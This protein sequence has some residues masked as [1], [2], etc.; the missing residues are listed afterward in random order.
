[1]PFSQHLSVVWLQLSVHTLSPPLD[2]HGLRTQLFMSLSLSLPS[3][4]PGLLT[5]APPRNVSEIDGNRNKDG[6]EGQAVPG[7]ERSADVGHTG[8]AVPLNL[9]VGDPSSPRFP[10]IT[11]PGPPGTQSQVVQEKPQVRAT[12]TPTQ[13]H[14]HPVTR[15]YTH[16]HLA[17]QDSPDT[18]ETWYRARDSDSGLLTTQGAVTS[19]A[20]TAQQSTREGLRGLAR[21][22]AGPQT[23]VLEL[24][25][26]RRLSP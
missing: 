20:G 17:T 9:S 14:R 19:E 7:T 13:A 1:M 23:E 22:T 25:K 10:P 21:P 18:F 3:R 6:G 4:E 16:S 5:A 2:C 26:G 11:C 8:F 24:V 15:A 12:H